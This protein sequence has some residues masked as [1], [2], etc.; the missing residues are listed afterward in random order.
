MLPE[1]NGQICNKDLGRDHHETEA[2][3]QVWLTFTLSLQQ[4][5]KTVS[6]CVNSFASLKD[7]I[8]FGKLRSLDF[9]CPVGGQENIVRR[10]EVGT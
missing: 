10:Y 2:L 1:A 7:F 8:I 9:N 6:M 3:K 5:N 4:R